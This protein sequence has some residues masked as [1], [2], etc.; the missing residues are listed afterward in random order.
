VQQVEF[1]S[2]NLH[3]QIACT[4]PLALV[5]PSPTHVAVVLYACTL[6]VD[7]WMEASS[8]RDDTPLHH[9]AWLPADDD[10][11]VTTSRCT[12][13][14]G[15]RPTTTALHHAGDET[16]AARRGPATTAPP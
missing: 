1:S 8:A 2:L 3:L 4:R 5:D 7:D 15:C 16:R 9:R 11:A 14:P 10:G 13:E 6:M 12:I